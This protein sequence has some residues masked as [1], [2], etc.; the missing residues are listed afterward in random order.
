MFDDDNT[1]LFIKITQLE[2]IDVSFEEQPIIIELV[3]EAPLRTRT[4][5]IFTIFSNRLDFYI[6]GEVTGRRTTTSLPDTEFGGIN[7][8]LAIEQFYTGIN[9]LVAAPPEGVNTITGLVFAR[10]NAGVRDGLVRIDFVNGE[11]FTRVN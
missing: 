6:D 7:Y 3:H 4:G 10:G 8:N 9:D 5:D 11:S 2:G 1:G